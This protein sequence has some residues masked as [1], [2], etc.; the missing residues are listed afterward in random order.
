[1]L[2]DYDPADRAAASRGERPTPP[3]ARPA[4]PIPAA[5]GEIVALTES[6]VIEVKRLLTESA[7]AGKG[8]RLRVVGGGCS[9]LA[10]QLEF[11]AKVE[12]DLIGEHEGF[13]VFVDRK[14]AVYM[15]GVT[16][17]HQSGLSGKGFIFHNPNASNTCGCGESFSI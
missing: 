11:D 1:M 7:N 4:E 9:G 2:S 5:R 8:L 16:L 14:S 13:S 10:Y 12:G 17:D 3:A 15:R 6:A